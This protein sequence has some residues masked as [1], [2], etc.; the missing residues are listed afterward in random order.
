MRI[1]KSRLKEIILE[2]IEGID[3][4]QELTIEER[5]DRLETALGNAALS[6][7]QLLYENPA[8][9]AQLAGTLIQFV[10]KNPALLKMLAGAIIP[11]IMGALGGK[12]GGAG[13]GAAA[14]E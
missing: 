6:E 13:G 9:L 5:V 1:A 10:T 4:T 2:E 3:E 7:G 14:G 11:M 8:M 12:G